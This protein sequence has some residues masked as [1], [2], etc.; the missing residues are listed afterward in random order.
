MCLFLKAALFCVRSALSEASNWTCIQKVTNSCVIDLG[1]SCTLCNIGLCLFLNIMQLHVPPNLGHL[2]F[3]LIICLSVYSTTT[4]PFTSSSIY[5]SLVYSF[6]LL[7][8]SILGNVKDSTQRIC[9]PC[10]ST[11]FLFPLLIGFVP[12]PPLFMGFFCCL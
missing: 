9:F 3:L 6:S 5:L 4:C 7:A 12:F 8:L 11:C 2:S 1:N 10:L